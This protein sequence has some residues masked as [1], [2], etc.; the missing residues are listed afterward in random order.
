MNISD[1]DLVAVEY[2]NGDL[3]YG[4]KVG[5]ENG[6]LHVFLLEYDDTHAHYRY[7]SDIHIVDRKHVIEHV[8]NNGD[9]QK[10]WNKFNIYIENPKSNPEEHIFHII[11][12]SDGDNESIS[13]SDSTYSNDSSE[14]RSTVGSLVD[15]LEND[16]IIRFA[17][18]DVHTNCDCIECK[19]RERITLSQ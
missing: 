11:V 17:N 16:N 1:G 2:D 13:S 10:S 18:G 6:L 8:K 14:S 5:E 15:F 3:F 19:N 12:E 4:E 7:T 9:Y